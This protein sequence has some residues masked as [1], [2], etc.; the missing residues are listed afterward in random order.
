LYVV[1]HVILAAAGAYW[2][3]R[4]WKASASAAAMAG[5]AYACGGN[6]A[7]QYSNVVFLVGAAW[8]PWAA[9]AADPMLREQRWSAAILLGVVLALMIM[10]GDPEAAYHALLVTGLYAIVL[11]FSR[12]ADRRPSG[13]ALDESQSKRRVSQLL[14]RVGMVC[15]AGI[16]AY[17]L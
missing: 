12:E 3:A 10:G 2:L 8:L 5:I 1:L 4:G 7:F 13:G 11:A 15:L 17:G 14:G 16:A 9:L 6:V